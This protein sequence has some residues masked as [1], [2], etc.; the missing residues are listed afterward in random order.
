MYIIKT[1][2]DIDVLRNANVIQKQYMDIIESNFILQYKILKEYNE[3]TLEDF[4]LNNDGEIALLEK[5]DNLRNLQVLGLDPNGG[6]LCTIPESVKG[7]IIEEK[8][9]FEIMIL[10]NNQYVLYVYVP[11]E[12]VDD[13]ILQWINKYK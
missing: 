2:L 11:E 9:L 1:K 7:I 3:I 6:L 10:C 13:E 12:I 8:I 5:G 4:S